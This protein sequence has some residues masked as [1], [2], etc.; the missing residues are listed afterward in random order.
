MDMG[1]HVSAGHLRVCVK[2]DDYCD[3][4]SASTLSCIKLI[5]IVLRAT[6][7]PYSCD[8]Q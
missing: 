6:L 7:P 4:F 8:S 2:V 1:G 5:V 3:L